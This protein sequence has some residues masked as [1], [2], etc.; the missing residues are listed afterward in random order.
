MFCFCCRTSES[1]QYDWTLK[2]ESYSIPFIS[3]K[4][5]VVPTKKYQRRSAD[6]VRHM[7]V[8]S[9][10]FPPLCLLLLTL[11]QRIRGLQEEA[12][13]KRYERME[14]ERIVMAANKKPAAAAAAPAAS[15]PPAS[16]ATAAAAAAAEDPKKKDKK[17][18]FGTRRGKEKEK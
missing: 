15:A 3:P 1:P 2:R 6:R 18:F 13:R 14:Q 12:D 10:F 9:P 5:M 7:Q 4:I 8:L 16:A 17:R 11:L